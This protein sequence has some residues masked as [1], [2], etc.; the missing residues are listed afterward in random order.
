MM[1]SKMGT[2]HEMQELETYNAQLIDDDTETIEDIEN[3]MMQKGVDAL[4]D[5]EIK[6][7]NTDEDYY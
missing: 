3:K 2:K 5:E 7:L 1:S 4:T 6:R